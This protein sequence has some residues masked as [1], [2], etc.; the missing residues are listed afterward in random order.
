M[1]P[2]AGAEPGKLPASRVSRG[3]GFHLKPA[4]EAAGPLG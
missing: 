4:I 3:A 1:A 2:S